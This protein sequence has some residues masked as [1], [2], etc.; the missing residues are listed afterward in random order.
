MVKKELM[1]NLEN[2]KKSVRFMQTL[3]VIIL[4]V[5]IFWFSNHLIYNCDKNNMAPKV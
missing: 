4:V 2:K 1:I 5:A 3:L